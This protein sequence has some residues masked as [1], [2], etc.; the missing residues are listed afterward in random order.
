[1]VSLPKVKDVDFVVLLMIV[2]NVQLEA[3]VLFV[4]LVTILKETLVLIV[5]IIVLLVLEP[6]LVPFVMMDSSFLTESAQILSV[7]V[8]VNTVMEM[9]VKKNVNKDHSGIL[10]E[11]LAEDVLPTVPLVLMPVLV[12]FVMKDSS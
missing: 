1:M 4:L 9:S 10:K 8:N 3:N 11:K 7:K 6:V 2:N 5:L 12:P